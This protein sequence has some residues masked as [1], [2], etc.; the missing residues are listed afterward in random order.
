M[1][2][3]IFGPNFIRKIER[4][5]SFTLEFGFKSVYAK[6]IG[7][8]AA[9]A[10]EASDGQVKMHVSAP[11]NMTARRIAEINNE[12]SVLHNFSNG[13]WLISI[14]RWGKFTEIMPLLGAKELEF[15]D[16]AGNDDI[17][18][19]VVSDIGKPPEF[20]RAQFLFDSKVISP[21]TKQR[22][23]YSVKVSA[24]TTFINALRQRGMQLEHIY[25]Y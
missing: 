23:V 19:T 24:L 6:L 3:P 13:E 15:I 11:A 5:F 7:F 4:K 20:T 21:A 25:D 12:V 10:Y 1:D 16:I 9:T 14:P 18:V 8:G 17:L 2:T 22:L